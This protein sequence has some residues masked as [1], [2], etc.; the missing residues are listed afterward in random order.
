[1]PGEADRRS[2]T[3]VYK[4]EQNQTGADVVRWNA[5]EVSLLNFP[6]FIYTANLLNQPC[7]VILR[8]LT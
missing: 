5:C 2:G 8:L 3:I 1:M 6:I 7:I 4:P